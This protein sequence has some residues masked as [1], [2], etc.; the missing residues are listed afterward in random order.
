MVLLAP[1][2][3]HALSGLSPKDTSPV[4]IAPELQDVGIDEQLGNQLPLDAT[5]R[6]EAGETV[7]LGD[8]IQGRPVVL[9]LGYFECPMLC[10]LV[11]EGWVQSIRNVPLELGKDFEVISI[12]IN[13]NE[14]AEVAATKKKN[15]IR[16]LERPIN[17]S[18]IHFLVG[19]PASIDA[20]TSAVGFR[21]KYV[22]HSKQ[23][24]HPAAITVLTPDGRVSQYLY[25]VRY[26]PEPLT[27]ALRRAA[28]GKTTSSLQTFV[29]TCLQ[30]M[31]GNS[32]A[33]TYMRIGGA[34]TVVV[35]ALIIGRMLYREHKRRK[36][37][38]NNDT[39]PGTTPAASWN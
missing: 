2:V 11:A 25:G 29:M 13:P 33:L 6:N 31:Q 5:F 35:I 26:E 21:Y 7:R 30:V 39:A 17:E 36:T 16:G 38:L 34:V 20:V 1:Q 10:T 12:S 18:A 22:A 3:A 9:Q 24:S 23:Y 14:T 27:N 28:E 32:N 15:F 8:L 37:D 19:D 4:Y